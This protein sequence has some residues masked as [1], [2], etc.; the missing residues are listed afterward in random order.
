[1]HPAVAS[2]CDEGIL[3]GAAGSTSGQSKARWVLAATILG[4]SM[5]FIDG[6]VVNVALPVLQ[7][8]LEA[9]VSDAL[10]VIEAYSLFLSSLVLVGGSLGDRFGRRRIFVTGV[11]VFAASSAA[12][13]LAT[14]VAALI[15]A[16]AIQGIGAALLVPSS[17]AILGAAFSSS[18]RGGAIGTWSALTAACTAVGPVLGGW[19]VQVWSWRAVFF[20]N[21]PIAAAVLVIALTKLSETRGAVGGKLDVPGAALATL[22]LGALVYGLL[23]VPEAGWSSAD[24]LIPLAV[25]VAALAAFVQVERRSP[26][27]MVPPS[28][29]RIRAFSG[30]NLLTFFLYAALSAT[31]FLLP[32][33][34]I[35]AQ[36]YS[37]AAA[38]AA[39]LPMI[40]LVVSLSRWSGRIAD[41]IGP[42]PLLTIG[43][44]VAAAGFV[45][46]AVPG[47]GARYATGYLPAMAVL[48]LGLAIA[49]SP[50]TTS[51]LGSVPSEDTGVASGINN[52]VA[53][54]AGLLAIAA[55]GIVAAGCFDRALD[56]RLSAS[57]LSSVAKAIPA[58]ERR[59]LGAAQPPRG[60]PPAETSEVRQAISE[61][62]LAAFRVSMAIAAGLALLASAT[63][64]VALSSKMDRRRPSASRR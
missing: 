29:F 7:K 22:G 52:A 28:L 8:S 46:L 49:V 55:I 62:L 54:V 59:K 30:A 5:A 45:L 47:I 2:P 56:R 20:L 31:F 57:H 36:G 61:S 35:Q 50:L 11:A 18:E 53:R 24:V 3:R 33:E 27:P 44:A 19:L 43:P 14:S 34:L 26:N 63:A 15:A 12:C 21:L 42:R 48:G 17:L 41:R 58:S 10:W 51:V 1:M 37:P 23:R 6:T 39:I 32:F 64:A 25:G 4:S 40:L 16:R 60:L 13:G 38:G 9:S